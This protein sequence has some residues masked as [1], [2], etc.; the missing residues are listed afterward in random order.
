LQKDIHYSNNGS[1]ITYLNPNTNF[2]NL[3]DLLKSIYSWKSCLIVLEKENKLWNSTSKTSPRYL[4]EFLLLVGIKTK[5]YK[6][7]EKIDSM[8]YITAGDNYI[9][10]D[11]FS[12]KDIFFI[13]SSLKKMLNLYKPDKAHFFDLS[14]SD[15][16]NI[17]KNG[18][19]FG[20]QSD[21]QD[22]IIDMIN[23]KDNQFVKTTSKI[24]NLYELFE[25]L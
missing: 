3:D 17:C 15:Y 25:Q 24:E 2:S 16:G 23:K 1:D 4:Y 11:K 7:T 22:Y 20:M 5:D 10:S 9:N 14:S 8:F 13:K 12:K 6:L 21:L 19:L 18:L